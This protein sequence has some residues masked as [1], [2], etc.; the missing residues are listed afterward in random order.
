[1]AI[2]VLPSKTTLGSRLGEALGQGIEYAAQRKLNQ[3]DQQRQYELQQKAAQEQQQRQYDMYLSDLGRQRQ[4]QE[5]GLGPIFGPEKAKEYSFLGKSLLAPLIKQVAVEPSQ[6][7]YNQA[8]QKIAAGEEPSLEGLSPEQAYRATQL[9][10]QA[11]QRR[12]TQELRRTTQQIQQAEKERAHKEKVQNRIVAGNK[13]YINRLSKGKPLGDELM[14][15]ADRLEDLE[16]TGKLTTGFYASLPTALQNKETNQYDALSDELAALL[17]TNQGTASNFKIKFAK[18]YKPNL[19]Q[20][21]EARRAL[22]RDVKEKAHKLNLYSDL[23]DYLIAK[24]DGEEPKGLETEV[25]QAIQVY[26]KLPPPINYEEGAVIRPK[27]KTIKTKYA[28]QLANG[29][30]Q[31]YLEE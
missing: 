6:Q 2:Q 20:K 18:G 4:E 8:L 3:W 23:K 21:P 11:Q 13:S 25:N 16:N 31:P 10:Q 17:A 9:S 5:R 7:A 1:M 14:R 12:E 15:I 26:E 30:W 22:I 19:A 24:N 29:V 28:F 27:N